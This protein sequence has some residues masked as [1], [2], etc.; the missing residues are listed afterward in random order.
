MIALVF[1]EECIYLL[2]GYLLVK[3]LSSLSIF[4]LFFLSKLLIVAVIG[5]LFY[6]M[7]EPLYKHSKT[8][9]EIFVEEEKEAEET[10]LE[11]M[12][13]KD[14]ECAE[15]ETKEETT[16]FADLLQKTED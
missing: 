14:S 15:S 1:P 3:F 11:E 7:A 10:E 4:E 5:F 9:I 8:Q 16:E 6:S 12:L 13:E 2:A